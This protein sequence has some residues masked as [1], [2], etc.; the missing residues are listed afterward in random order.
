MKEPMLRDIRRQPAYWQSLLSRGPEI[1]KIVREHLTLSEGGRL[2]A[3]GCGDGYIAA[4]SVTQIA[5]QSLG[6]F[7]KPRSAHE[8]LCFE[9]DAAG[10]S[11]CLIAI[12]MSGN[13]DRTVEAAAAAK[14]RQVKVLV[15][16]EEEGGRLGALCP[17]ISA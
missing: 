7:Y 10:P 17:I 15:L 11:D 14:E 2:F 1:R 13:V 4:R 6:L 8:F 9:A 12:S 3:I 16:T 5:T